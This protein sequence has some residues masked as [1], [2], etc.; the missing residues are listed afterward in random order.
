MSNKFK[1]SIALVA[2]VIFAGG[3]AYAAFLQHGGEKAVPAAVSDFLG[4]NYPD[5]R[6][7]SSTDRK[8]NGLHLY[9]LR[10]APGS[11]V[12]LDEYY[13]GRPAAGG[14]QPLLNQT[15]LP[16]PVID[17]VV[18][19]AACPPPIGDSVKEETFAK[20]SGETLIKLEKPD[21]RYIVTIS[22][23]GE[24]SKMIIGADGTVFR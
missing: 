19:A 21:V 2:V 7:D 22:Q 3:I 16:Q 10:F 14:P 1:V 24:E 11:K 17:S 13:F 9:D 20:P 5:A 18:Q 15:D 6:I 8:E 4:K 23:G 12:S